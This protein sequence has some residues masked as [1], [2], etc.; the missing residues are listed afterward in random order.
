MI[1]HFSKLLN[2]ACMKLSLAST[3]KDAAIEEVARLLD[4]QPGM[5][6][7][8]GFYHDLLAREELDT[9]C[10]GYEIAVPHG[11]TTHVSKIMLAV[12]RSDTGVSYP[13]S[14]GK[15]RLLLVLATPKS[16]PRAY[17][18]TI[19]EMCRLLHDKENRAALLNAPTPDAFIKIVAAAEEKLRI[20]I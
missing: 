9:T 17:L 1:D 12:G 19:S 10:F 13:N 16:A 4:G 3:Q 15:V 8:Q 6:D 11:R 18:S 5:T 14:E 20:K 7:Y 2:P